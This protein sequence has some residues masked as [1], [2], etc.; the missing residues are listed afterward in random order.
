MKVNLKYGKNLNDLSKK[1]LNNSSSRYN[2]HTL[3]L[4]L[5]SR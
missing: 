3:C 5:N 4:E 2:P 1:E